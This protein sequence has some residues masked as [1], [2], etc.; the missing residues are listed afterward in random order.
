MSK[1]ICSA[2]VNTS[3][4]SWNGWSTR[5]IAPRS[6][7]S[8]ARTRWRRV[9]ASDHSSS[10]WASTSPGAVSATVVAHAAWTATHP[11]RRPS[12]VL[13][14]WSSRPGNRRLSSAS[15]SGTTS[16][17]LTSRVPM[18][19]S[20]LSMSSPSTSTLRIVTPLRSEP[21][22]VAPLR[23]ARTKRPPSS[24]SPEKV[25]MSP[26]WGRPPTGDR[27]RAQSSMTAR[28]S[29]RSRARPSS[30]ARSASGEW[31]CQSCTSCST[32]SAWWVR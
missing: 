27:S 5:R 4:I 20:W 30:I 1:P 31:R 29:S 23:L 8:V 16:T 6:Q 15:T 28:P 24:S 19:R 11:S 18:N 7:V 13:A 22:K 32:R 21:R 2:P 26:S 14:C 25:V 17:P 10:T 9:W 12:G 3:P